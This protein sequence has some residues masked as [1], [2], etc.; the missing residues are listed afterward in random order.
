MNCNTTVINA[1]AATRQNYSINV[2]QNLTQLY[3]VTTATISNLPANVRYMQ[4]RLWYIYEYNTVW[5][6]WDGLWFYTR[7]VRSGKT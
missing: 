1:W 3:Q 7:P 2:Y 4:L 6:I 5:R